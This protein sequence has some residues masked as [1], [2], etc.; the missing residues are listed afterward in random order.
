MTF[1][2]FGNFQ[3]IGKA[4]QILKPKAESFKSTSLSLEEYQCHVKYQMIKY[5]FK[6]LHNFYIT[7]NIADMKFW[8]LQS[9]EFEKIDYMTS[10]RRSILTT[11]FKKDPQLQLYILYVCDFHKNRLKD[12]MKISSRYIVD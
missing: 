3:G 8:D 1:S 2:I 6:C 5:L 4:K 10:Y 7:G 11:I 9:V 12:I